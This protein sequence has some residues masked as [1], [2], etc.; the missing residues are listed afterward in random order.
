MVKKVY[1]SGPMSGLPNLNSELFFA[2]EDILR[3]KGYD[4]FNPART[5]G[6]HDWLTFII[7][8]LENIRSCDAIYFLPNWRKSP[9][10]R[11]EAIVAHRLKLKVLRNDRKN[12]S[13]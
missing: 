10:A 7:F 4:V 2:T 9:G 1:I 3:S 11:I 5:T 6:D 8:D 13:P 12:P